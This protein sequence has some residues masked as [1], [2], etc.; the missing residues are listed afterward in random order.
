VGQGCAQ[1]VLLSIGYEI[2][3]KVSRLLRE[4]SESSENYVKLVKIT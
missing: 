1:Q 3:A 4:S 2:Y